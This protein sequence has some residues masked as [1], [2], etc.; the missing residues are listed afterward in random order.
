MYIDSVRGTNPVTVY[1]R[2]RTF[3]NTVQVRVRDAA[4]ALIAERFTTSTGE[5]GHHNPFSKE[6]W[7]TREPGARIIVEAFEYSANDG[8]VRSLT[9]DTIPYRTGAMTLNLVFPTSDCTVTG[10][11]QRSVPRTVSLA[12]LL[13][14]SL[15]AG[16]T[17]PEQSAGA[18]SPF[19]RGAAVNSVIL[20]GSEVTVDFNERLQNV[21][22]ACAAQ[23]IRAAV[24]ETLK[25]LPA[26]TNVLITAGGSREQALQP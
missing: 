14:E 22:G 13:V 9:S 25:K 5:M 11:F 15:V 8:S 20:R 16:P 6:V 4:G 23:G 21:G 18:R 3:E 19:P 10:T 17:T 24:T 1:G 7:L 26:V 12:R 2:A